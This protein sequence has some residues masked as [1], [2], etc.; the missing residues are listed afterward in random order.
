MNDSITTTSHALQNLPGFSHSIS[1]SQS[2]EESAPQPYPDFDLSAYDELEGLPAAELGVE[3]LR[4][5]LLYCLLV[6]Y[7][8]ETVAFP[9]SDWCHFMRLAAIERQYLHTNNLIQAIDKDIKPIEK[10]DDYYDAHVYRPASALGVPHC[11]ARTAIRL[12]ALTLGINGQHYSYLDRYMLGHPRCLATKLC[13]DRDYSIHI[14]AKV[15]VYLLKGI[16]S[17]PLRH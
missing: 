6:D 14:V 10:R 4:H 8:L 7:K 16:F 17:L 5:L 11:V 15:S 12:F 1:M 3:K 13:Y 2:F 9:R